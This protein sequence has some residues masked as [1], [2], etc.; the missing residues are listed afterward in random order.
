MI[1]TGVSA[2]FTIFT[3]VFFF[4]Y[5]I[6][7][8][9]TLIQIFFLLYFVES[10]ICFL[11]GSHTRVLL[12]IGTPVSSNFFIILLEKVLRVSLVTWQ[13]LVDASVFWGVFLVLDDLVMYLHCYRIS[14]QNQNL[15]FFFFFLIK[16]PHIFI[17][18]T[19]FICTYKTLYVIA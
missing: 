10:R 3:S 1:T 15:H 5:S 19:T 9:D 17:V 7:K 12:V 6:Y 8:T 16:C 18:Y 11:S 13:M 2:L 4:F 14:C